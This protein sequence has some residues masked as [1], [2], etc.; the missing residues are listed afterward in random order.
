MR[1]GIP[2]G[3][4]YIPVSIAYAII[5]RQAGFTVF[6][7]CTMS[8]GVFA[9][10]AQM[11]AIGMYAQGASIITI[12]IATFILNL[13]HF[14]MSTCV[15]NKAGKGSTGLKLIGAFGVTDE[16]FAVF[17]TQAE[18]RCTAF[19]FL[20]LVTAAYVSWNLGTVV[21]AIASDLLPSA[22]T[23]SLSIA[24]YAMFIGMIVPNMKGNIRIAVLVAF[25]AVVNSVLNIFVS[26]S[27]SLII[28]TL[29]CAA[30]GVFFV[31]G[32]NNDAKGE[33]K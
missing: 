28:S 3:I 19:S 30:A 32:K 16:T 2:I 33:N 24:L 1:S 22:V 10:A 17:T 13:R 29:V 31:D 9:G 14:I 11:M 25:T 15:V 21:G 6:E 26:S 4:G 18:Y 5:A 12:I 27:L 20:G 7:T 23:A 8:L